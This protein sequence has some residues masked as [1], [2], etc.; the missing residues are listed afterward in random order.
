MY[1]NGDGEPVGGGHM[2]AAEMLPGY[3]GPGSQNNPP[4]P[5]GWNSQEATCSA[6]FPGQCSETITEVSILLDMYP[7]VTYNDLQYNMGSWGFMY[8]MC[9]DGDYDCDDCSYNGNYQNCKYTVAGALDIFAKEMGDTC[10]GFNTGSPYSIF[11]SYQADHPEEVDLLHTGRADG[12]DYCRANVYSGGNASDESGIIH[13]SK[14]H[15]TTCCDEECNSAFDL[16]GNCT[17]IPIY[18]WWKYQKPVS[19]QQE[20]YS[21]LCPS[22]LTEV[23]LWGEFYNIEET[24]SL[25]LGYNELTGEIPPEIGCLTNLIL[26]D[27][28]HNS[29][30]GEIPPEFGNLTNLIH[31]RLNDNQLTGEIPPEIGN[32][33]NLNILSL[34]DNQLTGYI[35]PEIGNLTII[36]LNLKNNQLI[37]EIP[38][39][40]GNLTNLTGLY[41][42]ENQL[43][44]QIPPEIGNLTNL[45]I[46]NLSLNQLTGEI[47]PEI[48]DLTNLESLYLTNNQLSGEIPSEIGNLTNLEYLNL[49]Y[50]QL[51]GEIP[52]EIGNLT[53]LYWLRL[54]GNQLTGEIPSEIGNL[55]NLEI[56][57]LYSN[58]LTGEIPA[59]IGNLTNLTQLYLQNNQLTGEIP[60]EIGSLTNLTGFWIYINQLTGEIPVEICNQGDSTPLLYNNNL[61]PPYPEC[62]SEDEI[63]DQNC[64]L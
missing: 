52:S 11:N 6:I 21:P 15:L 57:Y 17:E 7:E 46:L 8:R 19:V 24:T 20:E 53:N 37:G 23:E 45:T 3:D 62:L 5:A 34:Y 64:T 43:T 58:L 39:E 54:F 22:N 1:L 40:I 35:P 41:L 49:Y 38:P 14:E 29:F 61:C 36:R 32:L 55:I 48:G 51:T 4:G 44:G 30:T 59:E 31:L 33:T 16:N 13:C 27:L 10:E 60:P 25:D 42:N 47:P 2:M 56:L 26:L 50:N 18:E 12:Y 63:G 28:S 9:D